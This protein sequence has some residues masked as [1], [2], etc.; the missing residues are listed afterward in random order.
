MAGGNVG[1]RLT[2]DAGQMKSQ[3]SD[4]TK[5]IQ[6]MNEALKEATEAGDWGNV[7]ALSSAMSNLQDA[8][9]SMAYQARSE[10]A[11]VTKA[12]KEQRAANA[13]PGNTIVNAANNA[14]GYVQTFAQGNY[15]GA[16]ISGMKGLGG[17]LRDLGGD[18]NGGLGKLLGFLGVGGL[19]AGA[20]MAGGKALTDQYEAQLPVIDSFNALYG[21][22][23]GTNS[24]KENSNQGFDFYAK[25]AKE[26][27]KDTGKSTAEFMQ[28]S[29]NLSRYGISNADAAMRK[30]QDDIK[31]ANYTGGNLDLI[32]QITGMSSRYGMKGDAMQ[33]AYAGVRVTGLAK[34]QTD[35]FLNSMLRI[36][37]EGIS[38]GF[39]LGADEIAGNMNMLY[40]LSGNSALWQGENGASRL[41]QMN[42]A[43]SS[44]T[45]LES[46]DDMIVFGV[47][48]QMLDG[49][50]VEDR[51]KLFGIE[52]ATGGYTDILQ[53]MEHGIN[54]Q[55][56]KGIFDTVGQLD[57]QDA[58]SLTGRFKSIF[59]VGSYSDAA[60][61]TGMYNTYQKEKE[62]NPDFDFSIYSKQINNLKTAHDFTSDR[63]ES[64]NATNVMV[65]TVARMGMGVEDIKLKGLQELSGI[66]GKLDSIVA[67]MLVDKNEIKEATEGLFG[68]SEG[69]AKTALKNKLVADMENP[70]TRNSAM[71]AISML[72]G[73]SEEQ[74][75]YANLTN[76]FNDTDNIYSIK[77]VVLPEWF[78]ADENGSYE[79]ALYAY[80][81]NAG[82][83]KNDF[84]RGVI[85]NAI[86]K[87]EDSKSEEG[88]VI[89][90]S[91]VQRIVDAIN[92]LKAVQ[93]GEQNWRNNQTVN[94][95]IEQ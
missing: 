39:V 87:A 89:T 5:Q 18:V 20:A 81:Q 93:T 21:H 78:K 38:R 82:Y 30:T 94:I 60:A 65:E 66:S 70:E 19:V 79:N 6:Q 46:T 68:K 72:Q 29:G 42:N 1:L 15:A 71:Q 91:E 53:L 41:S 92:E 45:A 23:V 12:A 13:K 9:S 2:L 3:V 4:V 61:I 51:Q 75:A 17:S 31:W 49:V 83:S 69:K 47:A 36:M 57:G 88:K 95:T 24:Y 7:A 27:A 14:Q 84:Y 52:N 37:Q 67:K 35:E 64:Q 86:S 63:T 28:L 54:D 50:S 56:L 16:A 74:Q 76:L 44:A 62:N 55:M 32:Q 40:K 8:R 59:E 85:G 77:D 73:L 33:Q 58:D 26:Y 22:N 11:Q 34:G 90:I 25:A 80:R 43:V 10:E 48:Q